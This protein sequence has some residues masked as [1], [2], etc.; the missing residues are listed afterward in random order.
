MRKADREMKE[1][2]KLPEGAE[3]DNKIKGAV[4]TRRILESNSLN[5]MTMCAGDTFPYNYAVGFMEMANGHL[6]RGIK[7][8]LH[9]VQVP[10]LPKDENKNRDVAQ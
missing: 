6:L 4:F 2:R 10:P 8:F 1:A 3:R 5:S 9:S 7:A